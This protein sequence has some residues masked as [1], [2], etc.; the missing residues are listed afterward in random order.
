[1]TAIELDFE[2][3]DARLHRRLRIAGVAALLVAAMGSV[4][5]ASPLGEDTA[6]DDDCV[7]EVAYAV[8]FSSGCA[9]GDAAADT[10]R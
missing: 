2:G 10:G 5:T 1:M 4:W 8:G 6:G 9:T 7:M 3:V